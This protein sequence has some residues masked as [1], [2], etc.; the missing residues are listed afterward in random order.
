MELHHIYIDNYVSKL[1]V[2]ACWNAG[3]QVAV[4]V[5]KIEQNERNSAIFT[6]AQHSQLQSVLTGPFVALEEV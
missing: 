3:R 6:F 5:I 4:L 1:E 2:K